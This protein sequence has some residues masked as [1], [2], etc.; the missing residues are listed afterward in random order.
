MRFL[1]NIISFFIPLF[2][3]LVTFTLYS[4]IVN[5]VSDY[6]K[7]IINDY[8]IVIVT[9]MPLIKGKFFTFDDIKIKNIKMLKR[10][11]IISNMSKKLSHNSLKLLEKKLP[12]F[13][14]ISLDDYPTVSQ[15]LI[16]K[17]KLKKIPNIKRIETFS[18]DHSTI[19][20]LLVFNEK[21]VSIMF[22]FFIIFS[23]LILSQ[24]TS[25]WFLEHKKRI[26]IIEYHGGS[27]FYS[28][29]PIIKIAIVSSILASIATIA[30]NM[31]IK[32]NLS[33]IF[34]SEILSILSNVDTLNVDIL[35]I[36]AISMM[37]SIISIVG[38]LIKYKL[39]S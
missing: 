37:I 2:I 31:G 16:I 27:I 32:N 13:Y 17:N 25:I 10:E 5:I 29:M 36:V 34:S 22:V 24:Q 26:T 38:V 28:A 4:T 9:K 20:S 11:D 3:V 18:S 30:L 23:I 12:F 39:T 21:V 19:Y 15:L 35:M 1:K 14:K 6:K 7:M 8:A 33:I